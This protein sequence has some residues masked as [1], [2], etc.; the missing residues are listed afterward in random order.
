MLEHS[1]HLS[2]LKITVRHS[3]DAATKERS[4]KDRN[5][6][7]INNIEYNRGIEHDE[8]GPDREKIS[9]NR[10]LD[11]VHKYSINPLTSII[12]SCLRL[13]KVLLP[14]PRK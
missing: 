12:A 4:P 7:L 9:E 13:I 6:K 1:F 8:K 10:G 11:G 2:T 14:L 5:E 3:W